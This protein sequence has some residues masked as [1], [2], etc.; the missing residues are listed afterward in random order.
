V[1][2]DLRERCRGLLL[3]M[4]AGDAL[5]LPREGLSRGRARRLFG[6]PP[7]R[8]RLL[9][10]RGLVSDDTE[11]AC[12][13]AQSILSANGDLRAFARSLAWRL[14]FWL[15]GLPAGAGFATLRAILKLW[16]GFPPAHS[17]VFSAG[18][19]PAMRSPVLGLCCSDPTQ[20]R[21]FVRASTRLTHTDPRAERGALLVALGLRHAVRSPTNPTESFLRQVRDW[22]PDAD[23]EFLALLSQVERHALRQSS[24]AEF[25]DAVG[26]RRGVSGYVYHTVFASVFCWLRWPRDFRRAVEEVILLGGDTDTTGAVVGGLVGT[27]V[28]ESGI[29]A[30]WVAGLAEWP[31]SVGWIRQLADRLAQFVEM[32]PEQQPP[33]PR[34]VF[35]P[36]LLA[37]NLLFLLVVLAHGF[38]RLL[39]PY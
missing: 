7:L 10:G 24:A 33:R 13:T 20:L 39:P 4:A 21:A 23:E 25:A 15:L 9:F 17:G 18:N 34:P 19:G 28:G 1:G 8:H 29:P 36:G 12:M 3:G 38:R 31:C 32:S 16:L 26:W 5:G 11:H 14:R 35:W 6:G 27:L 37:R 30:E 22:F 2:L